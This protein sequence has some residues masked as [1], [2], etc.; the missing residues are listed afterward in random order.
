MPSTTR[1]RS[2]PSRYTSRGA[3][4]FPGHR[5]HRGDRYREG[6]R[7]RRQ[8]SP[9]PTHHGRSVSLVLSRDR[10]SASGG[11]SA[12]CT[13]NAAWDRLSLP[14]SHHPSGAS[15]SRALARP[16]L[17]SPVLRLSGSLWEEEA[18]TCRR[19]HGAW[20]TAYGIMSAQD[21]PDE[22]PESYRDAHG[23]SSLS[24]TDDVPVT[25]AV[26]RDAKVFAES[27]V[28]AVRRIVFPAHGLRSG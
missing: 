6:S 22:I 15:R 14:R 26:R 5:L 23:V 28:Q 9:L 24:D 10:A 7:V 8:P 4:L 1:T 21:F 2:S 13:C 12:R 18:T 27:S 19:W 16:S 20:T 3:F 17:S 25:E 11:F